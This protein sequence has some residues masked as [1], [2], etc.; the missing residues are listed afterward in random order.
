MLVV[1]SAVMVGGAALWWLVGPSSAR[2]VVGAL[3]LLGVS[4]G[5]DTLGLQAAGQ[6]IGTG[7]FPTVTL[8]PG[9][10]GRTESPRERPR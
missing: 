8:A 4:N 1:G 10:A 3:V 5:F 6:A 7:P 9:E 2:R